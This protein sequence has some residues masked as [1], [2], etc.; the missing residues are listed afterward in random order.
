[1]APRAPNSSIGSANGD[2]TFPSWANLRGDFR[3]KRPRTER[4]VQTPRPAGTY[5]ARRSISQRAMPAKR[6][7]VSPVWNWVDPCHAN[8]VDAPRRVAHHRGTRGTPKA[9]L[10]RLRCK[11]RQGRYHC[12]ND[13]GRPAELRRRKPEDLRLHCSAA[14]FIA[15]HTA[16]ARKDERSADS[17]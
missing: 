12:C 5:R 16:H 2:T 3:Q 1:M 17:A 7:R 11:L 9:L 13:S 15:P 14:E 6:Q 10:Q 8:T 4:Q